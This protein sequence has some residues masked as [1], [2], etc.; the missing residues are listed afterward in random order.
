MAV[1][2]L[3]QMIGAIVSAAITSKIGIK[4]TLMIGTLCLSAV[5]FGQMLSAWKAEHINDSD[6]ENK[7][8]W[9][10]T[11]L[12]RTVVIVVLYICSILS[13]FG[14]AIIWVS[15]GEYLALC[16]TEKT[17]AFYYGYFLSIFMCSQIFGNLIGALIIEKTTG[18]GFFFINACIML[19]A[20]I[21]FGFIVVPKQ[22]EPI[23]E[24]T[25]K[26]RLIVIEAHLQSKNTDSSSAANLETKSFLDII[27]ST[28]KL[29]FSPKMML[30]NCQF[31]WTGIS[32]SMWTGILIPIMILQQ[33]DD[34]G[35]DKHKDS[36]CLY[37]MMF[38]GAGQVIAGVVL[39]WVHDKIG[40]RKSAL[41][42]VFLI[43]AT[44]AITALNLL[45]SA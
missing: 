14:E 11:F 16:T 5:V 10:D 31:W 20:F 38:F 35:S 37:A 33:K 22:H 25:S 40:P 19:V 8:W 44:T 9:Y 24:I 42:N 29:I 18:P 6:T 28:V 32:I 7:G 30:A 34:V 1:L 45:P 36:K 13:G 3:F 21:G 2:Y 26:E 39:G 43:A 41:M 17:Q 12:N 4:A 27:K 15:Q 23:P